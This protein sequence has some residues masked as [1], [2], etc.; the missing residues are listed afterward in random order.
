M[1]YQIQEI[2]NDGGYCLGHRFN[3]L[4][5]VDSVFV[6]WQSAK[7]WLAEARSAEVRS[8]KS[9]GAT[10]HKEAPDVAKNPPNPLVPVNAAQAKTTAPVGED[11]HDQPQVPGENLPNPS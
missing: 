10:P 4:G 6:E 5:I 1:Y 2:T 11:K 9:T 7:V 3:L 8:A